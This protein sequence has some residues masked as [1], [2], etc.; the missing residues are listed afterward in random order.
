MEKNFD[1]AIGVVAGIDEAT[2]K[3]FRCILYSNSLKPVHTMERV[4][5]TDEDLPKIVHVLQEQGFEADYELVTMKPEEWEAKREELVEI[6]KGKAEAIEAQQAMINEQYDA[7]IAETEQKANVKNLK[8]HGKAKKAIIAIV[9]AAALVAGGYAIVKNMNKDAQAPNLNSP[10]I[11]SEIPSESTP[12]PGKTVDERITA[13]HELFA[14]G[15]LYYDITNPDEVEKRVNLLIGYFEKM[16]KS[17]ITKGE[18]TDFFLLINGIKPTDGVDIDELMRKIQLAAAYDPNFDWREVAGQEIIANKRDSAYLDIY[19]RAINDW[20]TAAESK[21]IKQVS[22]MGKELVA[23]SYYGII[24]KEPLETQ[25]QGVGNVRFQNVSTEMQAF[26]TGYVGMTLNYPGY[27]I[28]EVIGSVTIQG[29]SIDVNYVAEPIAGPQVVPA[30]E[31]GA[32]DKGGEQGFAQA[33]MTVIVTKYNNGEYPECPE[34]L[35]ARLNS[36][37]NPQSVKTL[38]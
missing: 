5:A 24:L 16:Q 19:L 34:E 8:A 37:A 9:T 4:L 22:S 1:K 31:K 12:L 7:K 3:A 29:D 36:L 10:S 11:T 20:K 32:T 23:T 35:Q 21:N 14:K 13:M 26:I 15:E 25:V 28:K 2:Q 18:A 17:S 38:K 30:G 6:A 33:T 27:D